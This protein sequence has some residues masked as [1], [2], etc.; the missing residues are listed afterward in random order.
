MNSPYLALPPCT[1]S[2]ANQG[3]ECNSSKILERSKSLAVVHTNQKFHPNN[4]KILRFE[5]HSSDL[6]AMAHIHANRLAT[7]R[8]KVQ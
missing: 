8:A 6:E 3:R 1:L 2:I 5:H 4:K 7:I